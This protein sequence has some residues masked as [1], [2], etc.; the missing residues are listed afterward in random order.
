MSKKYVFRSGNRVQRVKAQV[1]GEEL[2]RIHKA[3]GA[4]LPADVVDESRPDE[5]P[6]H[7]AFEWRD[8]VAAEE[9]RCHTA[10]NLIRS[11]HV[12]NEKEESEP[13]YVSVV[14][15]EKEREYQPIDVIVQSPNLYAMAIY[16]AQQRIN[17][18]KKS[19]EDLQRAA[20]GADVDQKQLAAIRIAMQALSTAS[21]AIQALH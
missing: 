9:W 12:V 16:E 1:V 6:L 15:Q 19:L 13:V 10:R 3:K 11:V 20:D 2:E 14:T 17:S 7:D 18:A 21:G 4:L 8:D 5:A